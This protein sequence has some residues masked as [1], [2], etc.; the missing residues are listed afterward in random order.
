[1]PSGDSAA[2]ASNLYNDAT[3]AAQEL[4]QLSHATSVAQYQSTLTSSGFQQTLDQF[5][6]DYTALGTALGAT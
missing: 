6:Q 4:T 3:K 1:M 5:D 2:A